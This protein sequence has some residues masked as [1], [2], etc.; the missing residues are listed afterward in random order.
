MIGVLR[1]F[2]TAL[3]ALPMILIGGVRADDEGHTDEPLEQVKANV[4]AKKAVLVDVR[5][6][7]EWDR[8]HI[9]GAALVPLSRLAGWEHDGMTAEEKAALAKS[10]TRGSVVYCHC[11]AGHRAVSGAEILRKLGYDARALKPGYDDLIKA[12]FARD[13]ASSPAAESKSK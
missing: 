6:K 1:K 7:K 2:S 12:G 5:E 8:G 13:P 4:E 10:L 9:K 11:R 3:A